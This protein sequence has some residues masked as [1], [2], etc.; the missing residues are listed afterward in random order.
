MQRPRRE[1]LRLG[2]L[3]AERLGLL[4]F[5]SF[6]ADRPP[7]YCGVEQAR[8]GLKIIRNSLASIADPHG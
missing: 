6:V 7:L 3:E 1:L 2:R 5:L 8:F 4:P